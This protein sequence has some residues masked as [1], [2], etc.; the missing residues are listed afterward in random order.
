MFQIL[1]DGSLQGW[2]R[3]SRVVCSGWADG[4][5]ARLERTDGS[6][7]P[8]APNWDL[9]D[10][11]GV[12]TEPGAEDFVEAIPAHIRELAGAF[13]RRQWLALDALRHVGGFEAFVEQELAGAG[14]T[15]TLMCWEIAHS[16]Y[17]PS[18]ERHGLAREIMTAKRAELLSR[19]SD[20]AVTDRH[21]RLIN[22]VAWHQVETEMLWD[23][24]ALS[25]DKVVADALAGAALIHR[26][27][28]DVVAAMPAWLRVPALLVPIVD[29]R[30]PPGIVLKALQPLLDAPPH[31][32][33]RIRASLA[34]IAGWE[35]LTR[36]VERWRRAVVTFP[37]P[38]IAG[39][40]RLVAIPDG[41]DLERE[42]R[43][44]RH[45]VANYTAQA[46]RGEAAFF[47]WL[48]PERATVQLS[49]GP[50]GWRLV[51]HLGPGNAQLSPST[52]AAIRAE[53]AVQL[54]GTPVA[55]PSQ[56]DTYI[57]GTPYHRAHAVFAR[58]RPGLR[59]TLRREPTNP[60]DPQAIAVLTEDGAKLGYV[61]HVHNRDPAARLD[62]G[63]TLEAWIAALDG[64]LDI[65]IRV[66]RPMRAAA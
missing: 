38:P 6:W 61:P 31:L 27:W 8:W 54:A 1:D 32:R 19:L 16:Q 46:M 25:G 56:L 45:C 18:A 53:V 13:P 28:L 22:K 66:G 65:R 26:E 40:P 64:P 34:T 48:G 14:L 47:R 36:R 5:V 33:P 15:F 20:A 55:A 41:L 52:V 3:G 57:A 23:L 37:P 50:D 7:R 49:R 60:Y 2:F 63:E 11:R 24:L 30:F 21:V 44:M 29:G 62:A 58:L 51:Q 59:L 12:S 43:E 10:Y 9:F 17:R 42:G 35:D 4:L 39:T